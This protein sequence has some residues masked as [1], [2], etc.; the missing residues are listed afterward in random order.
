VM[1]VDKL[2]DKEFRCLDYRL[3]KMVEELDKFAKNGP[4]ANMKIVKM[5][6]AP[7]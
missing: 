1:N 4:T 5:D 7:I 3:N 6:E 2:T